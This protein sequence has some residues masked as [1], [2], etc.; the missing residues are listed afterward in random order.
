VCS[1]WEGESVECAEV[2]HVLHGVKADLAI[3]SGPEAIS[4]D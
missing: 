1:L 4:I 3:L 2:D